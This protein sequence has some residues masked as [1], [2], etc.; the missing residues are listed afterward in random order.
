VLRTCLVASGV[1]SEPGDRRIFGQGTDQ[2]GDLITERRRDLTRRDSRV[3]DDIVQNARRHDGVA[4]TQLRQQVA[5]LQR[6]V[7]RLARLLVRTADEP[8]SAKYAIA[9]DPRPRA[10]RTRT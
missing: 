1:R 2:P 9:P 4:A 5:D 10:R 8:L 3:F 6:M 7:V